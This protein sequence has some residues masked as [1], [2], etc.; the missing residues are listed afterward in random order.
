M[1]KEKSSMLHIAV[2]IMSI[3]QFRV[4]RLFLFSMLFL[5]CYYLKGQVVERTIDFPIN[6]N[7]SEW[8]Q[9]ESPVQRML[10]LQ[11]PKEDLDSIPSDALLDLCLRFPY[12]LDVIFADDYQK[13]IESLFSHFNGFQELLQRDSI[14]DVFIDK[15]AKFPEEVSIAL[16]GTDIDKGNLSFRWF[17]LEMLIAQPHVL[18]KM[19]KEHVLLMKH[20]LMKNQEIEKNHAEIFNEINTL[21]KCLII[22]R[23][24]LND[25]EYNLEKEQKDAFLKFSNNPR[26]LDKE[27]VSFVNNY[28]NME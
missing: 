20:L 19:G 13:G 15:L 1:K 17:V 8:K 22:I 28:L 26:F 2:P 10:S 11:L 5:F 24:S 3:T 9:M 18:S 7:S 27:I 21:S 14:A 6:P 23:H 12:L 4:K 25:K 16:N